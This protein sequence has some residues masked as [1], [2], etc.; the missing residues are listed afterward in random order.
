M[1]TT[2]V[3]LSAWLS[4]RKEWDKKITG[5]PISRLA[6]FHFNWAWGGFSPWQCRWSALSY[7]SME[8]KSLIKDLFKTAWLPLG[9]LEDHEG[10]VVELGPRTRKTDNVL[11][12]F[13]DNFPG[14]QIP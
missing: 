5:K 7:P 2:R 6:S 12:N 1:T 14:R 11:H 4:R 9:N 3:V 13:G 10:D 8:I